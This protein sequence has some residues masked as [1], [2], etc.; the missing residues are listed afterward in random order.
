MTL[1]SVSLGAFLVAACF[2]QA[3]HAQ[4]ATGTISGTVEDAT[5]AVVANANVTVTHQATGDI[6]RVQTN[7][8]G[9]FTVPYVRIGAHSV[10]AESTGF[11]PK[12][13][14]NITL[15]VDQTVNLTIA[16]EIG[17]VNE[18]VTVTSSAPLV[19]SSTSSL[20]Q[21][22]ENR[23]IVELPL[24]GRNPF[25]LGL[26]AGN[27][28]PVTGMGTNLPFAGGGGRFQSN[29]VMLDGI[30]NNTSSNA[31][32]VG[33]NGIAYIPSVDAVEEFK[34]KTNNYSAE[35]GRSAGTIVSAT[36]KSGGNDYH[37]SAWNFLRNEKLDA[38]NFFSNAGGLKRQPFKQ[39]QFGYTLGG[40]VIVPKLYNGKNRTFF[41]T[42]FEG[43]RRR[44]TATSNI[45][46][47]PPMDFRRGDFSRYNQRIYDPL[48]RRLGPNNQVV[49]TPFA[50][51][52]IPN[53]YI[54]RSS[55]AVVSL[56]PEPN[57]GAPGAQSRNYLRVAP[58][59][60]DNDQ[61]DAKIDH[62]ITENNSLM[63]R[64]SFANGTTPNPGNFDGFIGGNS[65]QIRNTRSAVIS[66]THI[67]RPNI[68]NEFR[69]GYS[70]HN[71]SIFPIRL[72]EGVAF[73]RQNNFTLFPFP[74]QGFPSLAFNFSGL[75]NTQS[76]FAGFGAANPNFNIENTFQWTDNLSI[77]KGA[78][79]F[80]TGVDIRRYR[81]D[82]NEGSG[83]LIF[84]SIFSSSSDAA[85]SGSPFADFL[86][87][88]PSSMQGSQLL[89]W[90]RSRD[91][92]T[93]L[94]FQDDWKVSRKLTLNVGVR[95]ELFTQPL[96]ARNRGG[97]FNATT[98]Q[99]ALPG[100]D[101][102]SRSII[103][104]D[105]NNISPRLGFAYAASQKLTIRGGA[106]LFYARRD[107]NREVTMIGANIPN[108]PAVVFPVVS[109]SGTLTPPLT[110]NDPL[111][112]GAGDPTLREFTPSRPTGFL[113]RGADFTN[114]PNPYVAQWNA[115]IQYQLLRDMV[116]ELA[117]SGA[118]GTKLATR[119]NLNQIS[120]EDAMAGRTQQIHRRFANVNNAVGLDAAIGNNIYNALNVRLEK[121]YSAGLNFLLN[122]TWSKNLESNGS[123]TMAFAQNGGTVFP[124]DS[125]N[126]RRERSY[127]PLDVPQVFVVSAGY[128]LP[129]GAGKPLLNHKGAANAMFG[130]WQIN[131]VTYLRSGF[132]TDIR[133]SRIPAANQLNATIN[134]PDRVSGVSMYLPNRGVD[135]YFNP[136]AFSEVGTVRNTL[137]QSITLFG[138]AA[139]RVGRGPGSVNI[140]FSLFKNFRVLERAT[141]QFR[142]EAFNLSNTPTFFLPAASNSALTIGNPNFGKLVS[143]SA[144]GRQVQF[145]LKVIL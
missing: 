97:L 96:D 66:D 25:A 41:F 16:L 59:G 134:V 93:G 55:A 74:I 135:G 22:I 68:V 138:N 6:R 49:S 109:A 136:A 21:V 145:G 79:A 112:I 113:F 91:L 40:P 65:T 7:E 8:R 71:G 3:A 76:Q 116:L 85:G 127:T 23:K 128:E 31:G 28:V 99:M 47:I 102:F 133:T 1:R 33:A 26:L 2:V 107:P 24:N 32:G 86:F 121:R 144:T 84:G 106:G 73:A 5:G 20:G 89:D 58:R 122:Y 51:N 100:R 141:V 114:N 111:P 95:Y 62:R 70:R 117:Y 61:F 60:F 18:A 90:A 75:I 115:S 108:T 105:H 124:V 27:T 92:Y 52:I 54:N 83:Q 12:T 139:R 29:D 126:L 9:E 53:S 94:Y 88:Y 110:V 131:S 37:G 140:D 78:H 10:T 103:K 64:F 118:K 123:S 77:T 120:F 119:V 4:V 137:G 42:D 11:R 13:L 82:R 45:L 39:N 67:F 72:E 19:D 30:D 130:G 63:G 104:G 57:F 15:R 35:F 101:G 46:D 38:N 34:V 132:P 143:S 43:T 44:T 50:G 129:F 48:A 36:I 142:A 69:A 125:Y 17:T 98:G 87:G 14:T 81:Y 80:K 56:L